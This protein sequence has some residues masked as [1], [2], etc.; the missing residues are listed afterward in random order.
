MKKVKTI[1]EEL[2]KLIISMHDQ[3]FSE[4]FYYDQASHVISY[5][6]NESFPIG[7]V[8]IDFLGKFVDNISNVMRFIYTVITHSGAEG[9]LFTDSQIHPL[10]KAIQKDKYQVPC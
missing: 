4:D 5:Q 2:T 8:S 3:G 9:L 7:E 6:L 1:N 10:A